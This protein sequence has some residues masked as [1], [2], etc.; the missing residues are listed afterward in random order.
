[1]YPWTDV[2]CPN[3]HRSASWPLDLWALGH[4]RQST[5]VTGH[6]IEC[7]DRQFN[8]IT[9]RFIP[10]IDK[11]KLAL[12]V[13]TTS[14]PYFIV[15]FCLTNYDAWEE[16]GDVNLFILVIDRYWFFITDTDYLHV[17][18]P[19]NRYAEPI[20]IYCIKYRVK[21]ILLFQSS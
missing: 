15:L 3:E 6:V 18:V 12:H 21:S 2:I 1:M 16:I 7:I 10:H 19:D 20:F 11:L 4:V 5:L 14:F 13:F 17:Y 9:R 8:H